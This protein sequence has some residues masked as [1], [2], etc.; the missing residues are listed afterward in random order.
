MNEVF[1]T[2][3]FMAILFFFLGTGVWV[4]LSLTAAAAIGMMLFTSR[5]VGDAMAT[6]IWG[7]ASSWS[8]TALQ[9]SITALPDS[10]AM[11]CA[12]TS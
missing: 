6:T 9:A 8:L 12:P 2:I 1:L 5:P 11:S 3:S 4:A 10:P 7:A